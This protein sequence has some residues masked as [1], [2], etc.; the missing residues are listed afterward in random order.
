V[1]AT[2]RRLHDL[3]VS[4]WWAF[5]LLF[6]IF[7]FVFVIYLLVALGMARD[8]RFGPAPPPNSPGMTLGTILVGLVLAGFI[9]LRF[10]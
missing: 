8:N 5:F 6:P 9:A 4:G 7:Q 10:P 3:D 2:R 1:N